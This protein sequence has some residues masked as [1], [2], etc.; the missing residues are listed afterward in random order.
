MPVF[1][2][3][4]LLFEDLAFLVFERGATNENFKKSYAERPNVGFPGVMRES[5]ST[6]RGEILEE[7]SCEVDKA[8]E[9]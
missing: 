2:Q 9:R 8:D 3:V 5:T 6:L 7:R 4:F 1:L